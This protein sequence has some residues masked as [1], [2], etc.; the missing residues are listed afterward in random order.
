MCAKCCLWVN[1]VYA[2]WALK[3]GDDIKIL[4]NR[5]TL[6]PTVGDR[7]VAPC[8]GVLGFSPALGLGAGG[9]QIPQRM[10]RASPRSLPRDRSLLRE[11]RCFGCPVDVQDGGTRGQLLRQNVSPL[12]VSCSATI[13]PHGGRGLH[14]S[15]EWL[16]CVWTDSTCA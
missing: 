15:G 9:R 10:P 1:D 5:I 14:V 16:T 11:Q 6:R 4:L 8:W 3:R 2:V 13:S 12:V 7:S